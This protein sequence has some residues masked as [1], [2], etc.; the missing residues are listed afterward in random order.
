MKNVFG[1]NTT[2]KSVDWTPFVVREIGED[3]SKRQDNIAVE[4]QA[5]EK[6]AKLPTWLKIVQYILLYVGLICIAGFLKSIVETPIETVWKNI[7]G[8]LIGGAI[9]LL[10]G[11]ALLCVEKKK[12]K[13]IAQSEDYQM[14]EKSFT[15][16]TEQSLDELKVPQDAK[17]VDIFAVLYKVNKKG[18]RKHLAMALS[19]FSAMSMSL[20]KEGNNVCFADLSVVIGIPLEGLSIKKINKNA[21]FVNWNKEEAPNKGIYKQYKITGNNYGVLWVKPYYSLQFT[22]QEEGYEVLFPSYELETICDV[23]GLQVEEPKKEKAE[24]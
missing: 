19:E 15:N 24:E 14:L 17:H 8:I 10:I 12:V 2:D 5:K 18:K 4:G 16:I 6:Q 21:T 3:L 13:D 20:F 9:A 1:V 23:T 11:V 22:Y 7:G